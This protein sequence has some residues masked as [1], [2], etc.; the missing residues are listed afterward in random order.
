M[1]TAF[2]ICLLYQNQQLGQG[3]PLISGKT[4]DSAHYLVINTPNGAYSLKRI[5][6]NAW[7]L[8]DKNNFPADNRY[9]D[10]LFKVLS[11][12]QLNEPAEINAEAAGFVDVT[13]QIQILD[14][15]GHSLL[16]LQIG[17]TSDNYRAAYIRDHSGN[18]HWV[19]ADIF[20]AVSRITWADRTVWRLPESTLS[21]LVIRT[22]ETTVNLVA[23][24]NHRWQEETTQKLLPPDFVDTWLH[25]LLFLRAGNLTWE[26]PPTETPSYTLTLFAGGT[27]LHLLLWSLEDTVIA[28]RPNST[29]TYKFHPNL[30][31]H[32]QNILG[33]IKKD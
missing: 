9:V 10:A 4:L 30:I 20:P 21:G 27:E 1:L 17:N 5:K 31:L 18:I 23:T 15:Q 11:Q 7:V 22:P 6:G 19:E 13:R 32:L 8:P 24:Q 3:T 33:E 2:L 25:P 12:I 16:Q 14:E 29:V 28:V 26:N